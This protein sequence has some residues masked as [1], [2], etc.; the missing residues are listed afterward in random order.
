MKKLGIRIDTGVAHRTA[1][2]RSSRF[3]ALVALTVFG[4]WMLSAADQKP[5]A[6]KAA[7]APHAAA[8][9]AHAPSAA[10]HGPSAPA[11]AHG[12][13]TSAP[14]GPTTAA[15]HGPTTAAPHGPTTS[16]PHG[17]TTASP[18]TGATTGGASGAAGGRGAAAGNAE[19]GRSAAG[20][21]TGPN[22][23]GAKS[24]PAAAGS[25][26][27]T[28]A[29]NSHGWSSGTTPKG[30]SVSTAKNGATVAKRADGKVASVHDEKRGMDV[31]RS[32]SG[33]RRVEVVRADHS[34]VVVVR[35]GRGYVEHPYMYHGHAY[36]SRSYYYGGRVYPRYYGNYYY[37]GVYIAPYYPAAYY[38]PAYYGWA[39]NPWVAP[40]PYAWGWGGNPW[41][42][43]Y[44]GYFTP[45]PV[46][47][48]AAF[49]LTDYIIANSLQAAYNAQ[50]AA[51]SAPAP[52]TPDV[53]NL[54]AEEV[55]RQIALENAESQTAKTGEPDM[56]SSS[57][58]RLL[59]D[60]TAHVFVAG[61]DLDL[62][63]SS[64]SECAISE[65]DALQMSGR[66]AADATS[67]NLIV[68]ASK[69]GRECPKGD[70]VAVG[71]Q[72]LQE[73]QNHMRETVGQ[74][75]QELQA[76]Q[77][78]GGLPAAPAAAKAAPQQTAFAASAPP[79]DQNVQAELNKE[80]QQA[81]T[82]EK[83]AGEAPPSAIA[84][85]PAPAAEPANIS[86]GQTIDQVTAALGNPKSIVNLGAKKIY[87]YPDMKITFKDGKVADVQ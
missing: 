75:M 54:I 38:A 81:D 20:R 56:A 60:G 14:H 6:P 21:A 32:L 19:G 63:D 42:G 2:N 24:A 62:V 70:L 34:R 67:I 28:P 40:V 36:A 55:K 18:R 68:L 83:E 26:R 3:T 86:V 29:A 48:S 82:V 64:G 84:P 16:A 27:G 69:G 76:K 46:Y 23:A 10:A 73:M 13:T 5:A 53:K 47:P 7:P 58:Q 11:A 66:P 50:A 49:W 59:T 35:G 61:A 87:V 45:Y 15:P 52:L 79:P 78:T 44:G 41:Y 72:D 51:L 9:A 8:P 17:P 33:N 22:A 85:P 25:P 4:C 39:Y 57:I 80:S 30:A 65:G 12:P 74:G 37:R 71:L 43:Y 1:R 77:G 31:H